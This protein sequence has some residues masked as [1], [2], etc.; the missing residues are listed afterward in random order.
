MGVRYHVH[1]QGGPPGYPKRGED[2][3]LRA[4]AEALARMWVRTGAV[5]EALVTRTSD[6][7]M[8]YLYDHE[9]LEA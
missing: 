8:I 4:D 6:G 7:K 5:R 9:E 2:R 3:W 1:G